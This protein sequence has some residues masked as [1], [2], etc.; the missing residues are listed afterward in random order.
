MGHT[1]PLETP[2]SYSSACSAGWSAAESWS[3]HR[4]FKFLFPL[5]LFLHAE[6]PNEGWI[7]QQSQ[8]VSLV[9]LLVCVCMIWPRLLVQSTDHYRHDRYVEPFRAAS[10]SPGLQS[11]HRH[12]KPVRFGTNLWEDVAR[13]FDTDLFIRVKRV[14]GYSNTFAPMGPREGWH[15]GGN[16]VRGKHFLKVTEFCCS[17]VSQT[18]KIYLTPSPSVCVCVCFCTLF[19]LK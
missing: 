11:G 14:A 13:L 19:M 17:A 2:P 12:T 7:L 18:N 8:D 4:G 6:Q 10:L 15:Q 1:A 5:E 9:L 3:A 16:E